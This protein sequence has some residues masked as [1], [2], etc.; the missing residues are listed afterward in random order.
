MTNVLCI[1][2]S[3]STEPYPFGSTPDDLGWAALLR[4]FAMTRGL[5]PASPRPEYDFRV[6]ARPSIRFDGY[7]Q[8]IAPSLVGP[9]ID[10]AI[11]ML[12][13][14][15]ILDHQPA[16]FIETWASNLYTFLR[17]SVRATTIIACTITPCGAVP[18]DEA[19][20]ILANNWTMGGAG[21]LIDLMV[22]TA[23]PVT[24]TSASNE[25]DPKFRG[26]D[27]IHPNQAGQQLYAN[28]IWNALMGLR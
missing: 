1:G 14:N 18:A 27:G 2:D 8:I 7:V 13:V 11:V 25:L 20:R 28:A 9:E 19:E 23:T 4:R 6:S 12:G 3:I 5:S 15:N 16:T 24:S 10:I 26:I 17:S 22:D 21:G